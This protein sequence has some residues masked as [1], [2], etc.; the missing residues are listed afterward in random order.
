MQRGEGTEEK[1][2]CLRKSRSYQYWG[3]GE[4]KDNVTNLKKKLAGTNLMYPKI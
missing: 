2:K 4:K 3:Q 1:K